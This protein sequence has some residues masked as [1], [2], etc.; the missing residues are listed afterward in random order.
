[1]LQT[2][3]LTYII[4]GMIAGV[5][6]YVII[7]GIIFI[8]DKI[9][10]GRIQPDYTLRENWWSAA[11][12]RSFTPYWMRYVIARAK[13]KPIPWHEDDYDFGSDDEN[14]HPDVVV[15]DNNSISEGQT[16][17]DSLHQSHIREKASIY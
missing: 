16:D 8:I 12:S 2:K 11:F 4:D 14:D 1:M 9:S 17:V 10:F 5:I 7:N 3:V 6:G 15:N 13:G